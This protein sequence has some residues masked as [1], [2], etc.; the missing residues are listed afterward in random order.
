[1]DSLP[2]PVYYGKIGTVLSAVEVET[3]GHEKLGLLLFTPLR[4]GGT[5][6]HREYPDGITA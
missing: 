6:I 4:N 2:Y 5:D 3:H 1:M